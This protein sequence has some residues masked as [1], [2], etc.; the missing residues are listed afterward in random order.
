MLRETPAVLG[1]RTFTL[2]HTVGRLQHDGPVLAWRFGIGDDL[3]LHV[4]GLKETAKG[5]PKQEGQSAQQ[6]VPLRQAPNLLSA[7]VCRRLWRKLRA[8][9]PTA[10]S[11]PVLC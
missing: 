1:S 10:I 6:G 5:R 2:R 7:R 3:R 4:E 11:M 8:S 9:S